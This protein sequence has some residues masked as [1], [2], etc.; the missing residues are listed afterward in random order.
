MTDKTNFPAIS[1]QVTELVMAGSTEHAEEAIN[2]TVEQFGDLA[3]IQVLDSLEP[4]GGC[5]AP[6]CFRWRQVVV[7]HAPDLAQSLDRKPGLLRCSLERGF[8][9]R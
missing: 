6:A 4:A 8:D 2:E 1:R 9:R 7:G 3:V 5:H